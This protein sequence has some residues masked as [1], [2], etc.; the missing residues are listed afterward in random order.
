[1]NERP[2]LQGRQT[3]VLWI[4]ENEIGMDEAHGWLLFFFLLHQGIAKLQFANGPEIK[5]PPSTWSS[6]RAV[7]SATAG[8]CPRI[9]SELQTSSPCDLRSD[10]DDVHG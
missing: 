6:L 7:S 3:D 9:H 2:D 5:S 8:H 10:V 1:M 4:P